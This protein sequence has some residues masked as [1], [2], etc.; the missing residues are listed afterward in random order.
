MGRR[1]FLAVASAALVAQAACASTSYAPRGDGRIVTVMEDGSLI[2]MKD[3]QHF[4]TGADGL[5]QAVAGN[6]AAEEH[7]RSYT[8]GV[9]MS[10][11]ENLIGLG[12]LVAGAIV[13]APRQDMAGNDLPVSRDRQIAG[14]FL[15]FG[16]LAAII[17][18][19]F[20][21]A[22][23]QA[24]YMDAINVYND[25][26][27]PRLPVP[28]PGSRPASPVPLPPPDLP[29]VTPVPPAPAAPAPPQATPPPP[30]PP[31]LLPSLPTV[32]PSP[33]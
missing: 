26:V 15:F 3:G 27:P 11:A 32:P 30:P 20:Q 10:L 18:A 7:A 9:H 22:S 17:V 16:G 29:R 28:P 2:L 12:A 5:T 8:Q 6:P 25:G 21:V 4:P 1:R 13:A 24:N 19:G 14:S 31:S 23:A 33:N